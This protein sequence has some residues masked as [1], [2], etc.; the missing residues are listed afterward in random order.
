MLYVGVAKKC[1]KQEEHI[2][3]IIVVV[4]AYK[5]MTEEL[6]II[7]TKLRKINYIR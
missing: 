4:M 3:I 5:I 2:A 7:S 1:G 6:K